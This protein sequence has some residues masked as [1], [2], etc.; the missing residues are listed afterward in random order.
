ML[1]DL[2][3]NIKVVDAS[4]RFFKHLEGVTDP[5][6]KRKVIGEQFIRVFE[7]EQTII[8]AKYRSRQS[9]VG[10]SQ[11]AGINDTINKPHHNGA[12]RRH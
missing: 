4:D 1:N 6:D 2:G 9:F 7:E 10:L 11:V 3:L 5:E 8:G 12:P